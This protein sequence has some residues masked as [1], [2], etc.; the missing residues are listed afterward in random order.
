MP[1]S[2]FRRI[3][4]LALLIPAF[5]LLAAETSNVAP[6]AAKEDPQPPVIE[7][8]P[9]GGPPSDAIVLFDGQDLSKFRGEQIG[10][11]HV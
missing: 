8:G 6:A 1:A 3:I 9:I 7:P 4:A 11:A 10:R 5:Q 2:K